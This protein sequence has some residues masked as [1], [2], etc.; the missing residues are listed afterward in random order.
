MDVSFLVLTTVPRLCKMFTLAEATWWVYGNFLYHF[1]TL[2]QKLFENIKPKTK[3]AW[4]LTTKWQINIFHM[5]KKTMFCGSPTVSVTSPSG[6]CFF[7]GFPF[8]SFSYVGQNLIAKFLLQAFHRILLSASAW[9]KWWRLVI[10]SKDTLASI[11]SVLTVD[12]TL[13]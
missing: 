1:A 12:Q 6:L 7:T 5:N 4:E 11:D 13:W 8:K 9:W 2:S 10:T 3:K